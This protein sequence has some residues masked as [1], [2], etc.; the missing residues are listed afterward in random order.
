[1][2]RVYYAYDKIERIRTGTGFEVKYYH[3]NKKV[4]EY[5][6]AEDAKKHPSCDDEKEYPKG[7]YL[8]TP[9]PAEREE[10]VEY[11]PNVVVFDKKKKK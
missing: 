6:T 5:E 7:A 11:T 10:L 2:F 1:M 3:V 4:G 8:I 9:E